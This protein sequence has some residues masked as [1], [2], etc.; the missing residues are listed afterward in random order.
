MNKN[1]LKQVFIAFVNKGSNITWSHILLQYIGLALMV[2]VEAVLWSWVY[3]FLVP[4][5]FAGAVEA[6]IFPPFLTFG[7]ALKLSFAVT[8]VVGLARLAYSKTGGGE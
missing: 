8:V 6:G 3:S 1:V 4:D 5:L 7:Q 2:I